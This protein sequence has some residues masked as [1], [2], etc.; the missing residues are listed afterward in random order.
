MKEKGKKKKKPKQ[1]KP[2]KPNPSSFSR[3]RAASSSSSL[4]TTYSLYI[5]HRFT[6]I[7]RPIVFSRA[8][9]LMTLSSFATRTIPAF[10]RLA[11]KESFSVLGKRLSWAKKK[12]KEWNDI[13]RIRG[14]SLESPHF[15]AGTNHV[16]LPSLTIPWLYISQISWWRHFF[17]FFLVFFIFFLF[18]L[19]LTIHLSIHHS[20]RLGLHQHRLPH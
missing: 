16:L 13:K 5:D 6:C 4:R 15:L 10:T 2:I 1:K 18:F 9:C 12:K 8:P 20:P 17:F 11:A 3:W 19:L 14:Q 7:V